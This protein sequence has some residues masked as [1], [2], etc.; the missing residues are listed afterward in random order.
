MIGLLAMDVLHDVNNILTVIQGLSELARAR[1][2][3]EKGSEVQTEIREIQ[4]A[5]KRAALLTHQ[6]LA[7]GHRQRLPPQLVD[8]NAAVA[9]IVR[10]LQRLI[11]RQVELV[12]IPGP[13]LES[14]RTAPGQIDQILMNLAANARD[15]MPQGGR[16]TISTANVDFNATGLPVRHPVAPGRYAM[17][18]VRDT[19]DGMDPETQARIFEPFFTTKPAGR[20]TGLGLATV[21]AIV[22]QCRGGIE[23]DSEP[24]RGTT[25]RIYL[26][27]GEAC[28]EATEPAPPPHR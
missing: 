10:L 8:L 15:A 27:R 11:G 6:L 22:Q 20:G 26:P 18:S 9:G 13:N 16:L 28:A 2:R 7:F 4:N 24:G 25:F 3:A 21:Y 12:T 23:L 5:A 1:Q 17:L 19:G 14:V